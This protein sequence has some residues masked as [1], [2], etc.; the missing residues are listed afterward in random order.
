MKKVTL[1]QWIKA[2][3]SKR[4][5]QTKAMLYRPKE[6][7]EP[8]YPDGFCCIGVYGKLAGCSI[9][10]MTDDK[11]DVAYKLVEKLVGRNVKTLC[12]NMNDHGKSFS[13]IADYLETLDASNQ[14]IKQ[15]DEG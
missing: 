13:E 7:V 14:P 5:K 2:L 8:G 12:V 4:F 3:R 10:K 15:G 1:K 6:L 11:S 9:S